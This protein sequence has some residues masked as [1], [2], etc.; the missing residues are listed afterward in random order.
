MHVCA[1]SVHTPQNTHTSDTDNAHPGKRNPNKKYLHAAE[2]EKAH[3]DK[4]EIFDTMNAVQWIPDAALPG[5]TKLI[6]L[7]M[8]YQYQRNS[9]GEIASRKARCSARGDEMLPHMHYDPTK[10]TTYV[11]DKRHH[12]HGSA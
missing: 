2:L 10:T 12:G 8:G 6:N 9:K 7:K 5:K 1:K 11:A 3:N 4:L